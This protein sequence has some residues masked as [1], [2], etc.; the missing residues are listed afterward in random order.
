VG[1]VLHMKQKF[2]IE[3]ERRTPVVYDVDVAVVGGGTAGVVATIAAAR[4]GVS[5]VLIERFGSLGGC[6][7]VGRMACMSN[8]FV[9]ANLR[10]IKAGIPLEIIDKLVRGWRKILPFSGP[11]CFGSQSYSAL[12]DG[13]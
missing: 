4:T 5:V 2:V 13:L 1:K 9:D 10:R 8:H 7:T 11:R 6:P 3:P 12:R